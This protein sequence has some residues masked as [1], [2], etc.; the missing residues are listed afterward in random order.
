M[1]DFKN[2]F[3]QKKNRSFGPR[4]NNRINS[5]EVQVID[6][7]GE[8]LGVLNL[9]EAITKAKKEGLDLIEIAPNKIKTSN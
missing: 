3:F 8:N 1:P 2:N 9:Q 6:S 7:E 5:S 4:Y